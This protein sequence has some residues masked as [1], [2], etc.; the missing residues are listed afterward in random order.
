MNSPT[1]RK[2][3]GIEAL[4]GIHPS[5]VLHHLEAILAD[6]RFAAAERNSNF[7]R[8]VVMATLDGRASELKETVI[9][10]GVYGRP[11]D[12]DPK[13]DSIVR[14]EASRLRQKL[15]AYYEN[16]GRA[17]AI[18]L[19]LPSGRYAPL[20]ERVEAPPRLPVLKAWRWR[21]PAAA[22]LVLIA[23]ALLGTGVWTGVGKT[24]INA[25]AQAAWQE[26]VLVIDLDPHTAA[27]SHGPPEPLLRAIERF[28]FA[29]ARDPRFAR[30]WASLAEAYEY[31]S[32]F[33][34]RDLEEDRRRAEAAANQAVRLDRRLAAGRHMQALLA[35]GLRWD[36][37]RAASAYRRTLELEPRNA[38][39]AIEYAD[40]LLET[41]HPERARD[42]VKTARGLLPVFPALAVKESEIDAELGRPEAA[43]LI[44]ESALSM[45]RT[46]LRAHVALGMAHERKSDFAMAEARY[47]H[48]LQADPAD[49][50]ALPAYGHLLAQTGRTQAAEEVL[51]RLK[52]IN[53]N[54]RNC[55]Y[56]IA[57]VNAGLDRDD[58]AFRWL[59]LA[60]KTRQSHF[61][62]A[63]IEY[64]FRKYH[65]HPRFRELLQRV[66]LQPVPLPRVT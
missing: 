56:Q 23:A 38:F 10:T 41:G 32:G 48:V 16:E 42:V 58:E 44:A 63:A 31:A 18:R 21:G 22:A 6:K 52:Q 8:F 47:R 45:D 54:V 30:A 2:A 26:G 3:E 55:A 5:E 14:V 11:H 13:A 39:A 60:W 7:L 1:I 15:R 4:N 12:Y 62:Y 25:E 28:E 37:V 50:R 61:P 66:G 57:I 17:A 24:D 19:H 34:G 65:Q 20:F 53:A 40:L 35:K 51:T 36:F 9:A 29:V 49:R 59:E 43:A 27:T 33:V 64:R 46:Y